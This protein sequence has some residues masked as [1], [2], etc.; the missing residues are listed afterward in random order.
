MR[1]IL[2][3]PHPVSAPETVPFLKISIPEIIHTYTDVCECVV[4]MVV[5]EY[6]VLKL[7][8]YPDRIVGSQNYLLSY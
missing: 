1:G 2:K 4:D 6:L 8:S 3:S 7:F 5:V